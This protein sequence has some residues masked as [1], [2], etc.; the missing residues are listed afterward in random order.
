M[1]GGENARVGFVEP[2]EKGVVLA[3]KKAVAEI[4]GGVAPHRHAD[5]VELTVDLV[6]IDD[7]AARGLVQ[8]TAN[9]Q[10]QQCG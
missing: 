2:I 8:K 6:V 1:L 7:P 3:G 5:R 9:G 10:N 4:V